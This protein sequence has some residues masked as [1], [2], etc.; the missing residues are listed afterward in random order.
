MKAA[1]QSKLSND[2]PDLSTLSQLVQSGNYLKEGREGEAV[3]REMILGVSFP[4]VFTNPNGKKPS[5]RRDG[6]QLG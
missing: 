6:L 1:S 3:N 5:L 4:S 2:Y